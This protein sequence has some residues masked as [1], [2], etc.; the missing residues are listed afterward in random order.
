MPFDAVGR[1]VEAHR[2]SAV[3]QLEVGER[4]VVVHQHV[5]QL[6]D[7]ERTDLVLEAAQRGTLRRGRP[8]DLERMEARDRFL[9][10]VG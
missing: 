1:V 3:E 2:A 7:L 5:G 8:D 10:D 4:I 6:A 9:R